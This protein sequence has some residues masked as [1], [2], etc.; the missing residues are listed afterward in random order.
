MESIV[1]ILLLVS[2]HYAFTV[3]QL[4]IKGDNFILFSSNLA[5]N[6]ARILEEIKWHTDRAEDGECSWS[7]YAKLAAPV[8][9]ISY[10]LILCGEFT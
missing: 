10:C 8:T 4:H 6:L 7:S 1:V 2:S 3:H 5:K 9:V